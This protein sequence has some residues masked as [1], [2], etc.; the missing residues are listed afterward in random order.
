MLHCRRM[1][2]PAVHHQCFLKCLLA[3]LRLPTLLLRDAAG[4]VQEGDELEGNPRLPARSPHLREGQRLDIK[5]SKDASLFQFS[6]LVDSEWV[7]Q[8]M[9]MQYRGLLF[10]LQVLHW[11]WEQDWSCECGGDQ[12]SSV[13]WVSGL[14]AHQVHE[15]WSHFHPPRYINMVETWHVGLIFEFGS[16]LHKSQDDSLNRSDLR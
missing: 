16:L 1:N 11:R 13:F 6:H 15:A 7:I 3:L 5:V 4:D 10:V 9:W 12:G 14:G 8:I 2:K